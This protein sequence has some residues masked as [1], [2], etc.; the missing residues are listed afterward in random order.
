MDEFAH[1]ILIKMYLIEISAPRQN[2]VFL[3]IKGECGRKSE[4]VR[5]F[6]LIYLFDRGNYSM[7]CGYDELWWVMI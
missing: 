3:R 7:H 1:A 4:K 2:G 5:F 6:I